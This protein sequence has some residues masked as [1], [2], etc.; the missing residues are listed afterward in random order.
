ML[1]QG[2]FSFF[3]MGC[4]PQNNTYLRLKA[5]GLREDIMEIKRSWQAGLGILDV[6]VQGLAAAY[7]KE[8]LKSKGERNF[9]G[10]GYFFVDSLS[11]NFILVA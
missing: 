10:G 1:G 5:P 3:I 4:R 6:R 9:L 2:V 7:K 11:V 8:D